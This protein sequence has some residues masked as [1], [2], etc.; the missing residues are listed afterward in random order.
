MDFFAWFA[1]CTGYNY[2]YR[3]LELKFTLKDILLKLK[4]VKIKRGDEEHF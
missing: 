3:L 4:H 2:L 1:Y